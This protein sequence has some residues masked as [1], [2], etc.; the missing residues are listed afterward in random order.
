MESKTLSEQ[1]L[2]TYTGC[3]KRLNDMFDDDEFI[4]TPLE[5][6]KYLKEK[7]P[8]L[9]SRKTYLSALLYQVKDKSNKV[10][11]I[12]KAEIDNM[13]PEITKIA[14]NQLLTSKQEEKYVVW[15]ILKN[16]GKDAI[17]KYKENKISLQDALA[18]VLYTEQ[19]PVRVDYIEMAFIKDIR[20]AKD[21]NFNYCLLRVRNPVFIFNNYKTSTTYGRVIVKIKSTTL[22]MLIERYKQAVEE[23]TNLL[24]SDDQPAFSR[25]IPRAFKSVINLEVSVNTIRHSFLTA[26]LSKNPSLREKQLI[27]TLMMNSPTQGEEYRVLN[28]ADIDKEVLDSTTDL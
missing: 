21:K 15:S 10:Y 2:K 6:I 23:S 19:V 20:Q 7:Y 18:V 14:T 28:E 22:K 12:Y 9:S 25:R 3:L 13:R 11:D 4:E 26:F 1:S 16:A 27:A 24:F 8:N 5:V 17:K